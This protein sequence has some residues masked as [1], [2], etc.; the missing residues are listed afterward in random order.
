[1]PHF[2]D[3]GKLQSLCESCHRSIKQKEEKRGVRTDI[4]IDGWPTDPRHPANKG[5]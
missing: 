4:G 3:V 5:K 2:A 1:M